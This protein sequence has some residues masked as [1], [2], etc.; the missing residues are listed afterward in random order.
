MRLISLGSGQDFPLQEE[1]E[2]QSSPPLLSRLPLIKYGFVH[3]HRRE[4]Q[5]CGV[6]DGLQDR[7]QPGACDHDAR[8]DADGPRLSYCGN[9]V[10]RCLSGARSRRPRKRR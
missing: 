7:L 9:D 8:Q 1:S 4:G 3:E 2:L 10:I 5:A 6:N